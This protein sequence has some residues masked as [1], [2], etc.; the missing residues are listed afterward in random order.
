MKLIA[1][2]TIG[3]TGAEIFQAYLAQ[4][5]DVLVLPGQN[6]TL[7]RQNLYRPHDYSGLGSSEI[8]AILNRHLLTK[9]GRTWM[10]LTKYMDEASLQTYRKERHEAAFVARLGDDTGYF[11]CARAYCESYFESV[12]GAGGENSVVFYSNNIALNLPAYGEGGRPARILNVANDIDYWLASISQTRT[13]DCL[14]ACK[15]WLV[16]N[17]YLRNF[18]ATHKEFRSFGLERLIDEPDREMTEICKFLEISERRTTRKAAGL[19]KPSRPIINATRANAALLRKIYQSEPLFQLADT[20][21]EWGDDFLAHPAVAPLLARFAVFWNSTSHTNFDWV[22]PVADEIVDLALL[23]HGSNSRRELNAR[24]YHEYF[25]THSDTHE[26]IQSHLHHYLGV[27]EFDIIL[28]LLP[29]YLKVAIEYLASISRNYAFHSHSY[30]PVRESYIYKCLAEPA[31]AEKINMFGLRKNF[32]DMEKLI[33]EADKS[34]D[35]LL[36]PS[37]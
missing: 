21:N 7:Y 10:G 36:S 14:E 5:E 13:W 8:F 3:L 24:F 33:G 25:R 22:G 9:A 19:I 26:K 31:A 17:L 1:L 28:P 35:H 6:F 27:L 32:E 4:L 23:R 37:R 18:E 34:C 20:L 12:G 15:F 29:Y 16:N 2:N 30:I 11:Y